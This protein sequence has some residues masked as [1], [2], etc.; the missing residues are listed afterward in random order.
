MSQISKGRTLAAAC[1]NDSLLLGKFEME[2]RTFLAALI[3]GLGAT[4]VATQAQALS[5]LARLGL[6]KLSKTAKSDS[7]TRSRHSPASHAT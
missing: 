5:G 1:G 2:R 7:E 6:K 4:L 3:A